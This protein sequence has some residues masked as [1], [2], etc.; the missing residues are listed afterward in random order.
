VKKNAREKKDRGNLR[1]IYVRGIPGTVKTKK[2]LVIVPRILHTASVVFAY[3]DVVCKHLLCVLW[4]EY[5]QP[6]PPECE[7]AFAPIQGESVPGSAITSVCFEQ[8]CD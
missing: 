3:S 2:N 8:D 1:I 5:S 6:L 4:V 7:T